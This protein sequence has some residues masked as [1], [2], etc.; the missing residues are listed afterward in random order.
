V[1]DA[2]VLG[3]GLAGLTAA[4]RTRE[5]GQSV[6]V[7]DPDPHGGAGANSRISGGVF[8]LAWGAMNEPPD[9]LMRRMVDQTDGEVDP[10]LARGL[11]EASGPAIRWLAGHGVDLAPKGNRPHD[12]FTCQ[13]WLEAHGDT[14]QPDRGAEI[15]LQT[16]RTWARDAGV[17][18]VAGSANALWKRPD[19]WHVGVTGREPM[20]GRAVIVATGGFQANSRMMR[21]F[22]A[23]HADDVFLR[24]TRSASGVGLRLLISAGAA[25]TEPSSA[26]YGHLL[27]A[28]AVREPRLWP[29][30]TVDAVARCGLLVDRDGHAFTPNADNG[31]ALVNAMVRTG[32]P[33][34]FTVVF[35]SRTHAEASAERTSD[36]SPRATQTD[37]HLRDVTELIERGAEVI[38]PASI[39]DIAVQLRIPRAQLRRSVEAWAGGAT[40]SSTCW[41]A[42]RVLPGITATMRGVRVDARCRVLGHGGETLPGLLAAGDVV[43]VHG[44]PRG[45]YLGGLAVALISGYISGSRH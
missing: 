9:E 25:L 34:G 41:Y 7:I 43:G 13:P 3:G 26:V 38:G 31:I 16:L 28:T 44:G 30:P 12:Q 15:A 37:G 2:V 10:E 5:T 24:S 19:G 18:F 21:A 29:Q 11:A 33:S 42:M 22:V 8:H 23:P 20:T 14:S 35:D 45:G 36:G 4:L 6:A 32:D 39:T 17:E 40:D 1:R 27:S